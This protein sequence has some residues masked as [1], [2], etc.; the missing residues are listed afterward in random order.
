[1]LMMSDCSFVL[2]NCCDGRFSDSYNKNR[3]EKSCVVVVNVSRRTV[4][5]RVFQGS[6]FLDDQVINHKH[7]AM[8]THDTFQ[9]LQVLRTQ[10]IG[11]HISTLNPI[12]H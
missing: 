5:V 2:D 12:M 11:K 8:A 9:T 7:R 10:I 4:N 6:L 1:M 3:T